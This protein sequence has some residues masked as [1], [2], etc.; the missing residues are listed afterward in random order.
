MEVTIG[1]DY[2]SRRLTVVRDGKVQLVGQPGSVPMDVSKQHATFTLQKDDTW[3]LRNLNALNVTFVNGLAVE[4]KTVSDTDK[5]ELGSSHYLVSWEI[6]KG[7]KVET[8]DVRPLKRVWEEYNNANIEI[9]KRQKNNGLLASVPMGFTMLGGVIGSISDLNPMIKQGAR[10]LAVIAFCILIYGLYKRFTDNSIDEQEELKQQF[11]KRYTC[12]KCGHFMGH[13]SYDI[14]IQ[15]ESCRF[16]K[17][18][19]I[20]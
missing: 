6:I 7:P 5:I 16:C 14:L 3:E 11:Q 2:K 12:P 15:N 9:R 10:F 18:K 17:A 19:F 13:E 20:K 8:V 4:K 1:R